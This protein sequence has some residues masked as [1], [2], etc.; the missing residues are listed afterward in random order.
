[1]TWTDYLHQQEHCKVS[2]IWF[3]LVTADENELPQTIE[4]VFNR[5][6]LWPWLNN[7]SEAMRWQ[8]DEIPNLIPTIKGKRYLIVQVQAEFENSERNEGV[9]IRPCD[10]QLWEHPQV[11][12]YKTK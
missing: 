5:K 10:E 2:R 3:K 4:L 6:N 1:M 7:P 8:S 12:R 9:I 11:T